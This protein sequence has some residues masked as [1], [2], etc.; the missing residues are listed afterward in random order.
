[1]QNKKT[2]YLVG[3]DLGTTHTVVAYTSADKSSADIQIFA[4][5]QLV[6]PG[7]VAA[8]PLLP[9]VRYHP[10]AGELSEADTIFATVGETAI[11]GEAARVRRKKSRSLCQQCEKL[12]ITSVR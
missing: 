5:E 11:I 3:I 10:A 6:A 9:S 12:V 2:R 8:R 1:V 4:V 7:Q